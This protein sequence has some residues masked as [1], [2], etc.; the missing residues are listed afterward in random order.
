MP[1]VAA[2]AFPSSSGSTTYET[3]LDDDGIL[4]CNCPGFIFKKKGQERSCKHTRQIEPY[5]ER[6][7]AGSITPEIV[8]VW[9]GISGTTPSVSTTK[10]VS[11]S[12]NTTTP[13]TSVSA[14]NS[15]SSL[16]PLM[17][18]KGRKIDFEE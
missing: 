9:L 10:P 3:T 11:L 17:E 5:R 14:P 2:W 16:P 7:K 13:E 6:V 4:S 12:G 15:P 1:I 8:G 18:R